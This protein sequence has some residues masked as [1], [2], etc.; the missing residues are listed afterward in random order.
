[1]VDLPVVYYSSRQPWSWAPRLQ[2]GDRGNTSKNG[3]DQEII[4]ILESDK[5]ARP[6]SGFMQQAGNKNQDYRAYGRDDNAA[7]HAATGT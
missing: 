3:D 4:A 5:T 1:M 2:A 7:Y 6:A